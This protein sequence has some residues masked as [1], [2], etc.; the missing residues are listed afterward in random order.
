MDRS[1]KQEDKTEIVSG[2]LGDFSDD[3]HKIFEKFQSNNDENEDSEAFLDDGDWW[4]DDGSDPASRLMD[5]TFDGRDDDDD[6][7]MVDQTGLSKKAMLQERPTVALLKQRT[8]RP[9]VV[10]FWDTTSPDPHMLVRMKAYRNSV[11][12]PAHWSHKRKYLQGKKGIEKPPFK[13]PEYIEATKISEIRQVIQEKESMKTLK[14]KMREK[15]RPK[16][17]KM[18]IDYQT[19]HDAFFKYATKPPLRPFGDLYY[20][21]KEYE[22]KM[23][24][25]RA[26]RISERL[27][28]A[29]GIASDSSPPPWLLNMQ[30]HG[31]PPAYPNLPIAGLNAPIPVGASYG[32][33]QGGWGQPP[34]DGMGHPLFVATVTG[35]EEAYNGPETKLWGEMEEF[36]DADDMDDDDEETAEGGAEGEQKD[37]EEGADENKTEDGGLDTPATSVAGWLTPFDGLQSVD[38]LSGIASLSS[39][40]ETPESIDIRKRGTPSGPTPKPYTIL[41][42]QKAPAQP[43]ALFA[44]NTLYKMPSA[45]G[46]STPL[47]LAAGTATPLGLAPGGTVTPLG[48]ASGGVSTPMLSNGGSMTPM[49]AGQAGKGDKTFAINTSLIEQ[50]G[51]FVGDA[52]RE[53]LKQHEAAREK[54]LK[55]AGQIEVSASVTP[56]TAVAKTTKKNK[57][58]G[59]FKF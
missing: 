47:G 26:G 2:I 20:E 34:T 45:S 58:K 1:H 13:L 11:P 41:K 7:D 14:Q 29:L 31:P 17:H 22:T 51:V 18:D 25:F 56:A 53:Q 12:V 8:Y 24:R 3:F 27:T 35:E 6:F 15:V 49:L 23:K 32:Y 33:H 39:G 52:I 28:L 5:E 43:G 19:L 46:I 30:R 9:D 50:D 55:A 40:L 21:G 57:K 59:G 10:E 36:S 44:S 37:G 54:T 16:M 38:S 4:D 48:L 42:E